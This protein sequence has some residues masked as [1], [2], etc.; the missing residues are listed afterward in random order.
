M[1]I[2]QCH[3]TMVLL[4]PLCILCHSLLRGCHPLPD[5]LPG[6]HAGPPSHTRQ[7]LF[8]IWPV[9]CGIHSHTHLW[10]I[11]GWQLGMFWQTTC[12]LLC[13]PVTQTWQHTT[14]PFYE[15][16]STLWTLVCWLD[17]SHSRAQQASMTSLAA[18]SVAQM[19]THPSTNWTQ[20]CLTSVIGPWMVC[21]S[22]AWA[23]MCV[24]GDK[25]TFYTCVST[26][27]CMNVCMP[28]YPYI[29]MYI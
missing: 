20:S 22:H 17:L 27:V 14:Q 5:Q 23:Y 25:Y 13:V 16:A 7:Y 15:L 2:I 1:L 11:E 8:F 24:C 18:T 19:V 10:Q 3:F 28:V 4:R 12:V 21:S 29:Y 26:Y 6:E 9:Q